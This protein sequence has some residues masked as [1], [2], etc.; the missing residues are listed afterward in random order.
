MRLNKS[1]KLFS[2]KEKIFSNEENP[3]GETPISI[4]KKRSCIIEIKN[5]AEGNV[6]NFEIALNNV[7]I[8]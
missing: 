4:E 1:K 5:N 8:I 7:I 2:N 3:K 6:I